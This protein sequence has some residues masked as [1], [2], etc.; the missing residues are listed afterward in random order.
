MARLAYTLLLALAMPLVLARL[1][2]RGRRE[3]GYRRFVAERFGRYASSPQ[4]PVLWVHAV[5]VG[6]VRAAAPL[7][8]ALIEARP[9]HQVL[10]TCMTAAGRDAIGQ[11]Y[12]DKCGDTVLAGFLPYDRPGGMRRMLDHFRPR[13]AILMETEIWPNL[14][15]A[16][17][18]RGVPVML[19]N[20]RLSEKSA[21]GYAKWPRLFR[22]AFG[23]LAAACAQSEADAVR[24]RELGAAQANA[25]GNLKFDV[26]PDAARLLEGAALRTE[27]ARPVLLLASTR[28][29]EEALLLDA[30]EGLG[31]ATQVVLVPRHPQRFDEVAVLARERGW[32]VARRS[33][34]EQP[35]GGRSLLLGDSMGEMAF[36]Y[37]LADVAVIGGSFCGY[38]GQNLIEAC[39][40]GVPVVIGPS[41]FNFTE[42][43]T[44]AVAAGAAVQVAG[45]AEAAASVLAILG[46]T[47]E[48]ERMSAAGRNLCELHRGAAARHVEVALR[49]LTAP[50]RR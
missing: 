42:A 45:P 2:W 6:E 47:G 31:A 48:R 1:W 12:G 33:A 15:Q 21:R 26:I 39:A 40:A 37:G 9:D 41:V 46:N 7:V 44:L 25:T 3:P 32:T 27:L 13:I 38:G 11:V 14:L 8:K 24:L 22:P 50:V 35:G 10:L 16:C 34:G 19:A 43:T 4:R 18:E 20:A 23:A 30:L 5:S 29:G 17:V 28:E 36:Y 49:L